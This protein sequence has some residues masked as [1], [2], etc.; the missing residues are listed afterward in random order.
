VDFEK[1]Y[2]FGF[3]NNTYVCYS[4]IDQNEV[5]A[6]V[7]VNKLDILI[8]GKE[9]KTLQIGTVM[10]RPDYRGN[11]LSKSLMEIAAGCLVRD[12]GTRSRCSPGHVGS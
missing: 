3:W 11:G 6:N 2:Q 10:T 8:D 7:S 9:S 5:I 4:Y 12:A 1:W